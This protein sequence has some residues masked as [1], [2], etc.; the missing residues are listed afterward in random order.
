[1]QLNSESLNTSA[2]PNWFAYFAQTYGDAASVVGL[3]LSIGGLAATIVVALRA[4]SA[5]IQAR[6]AALA[7]QGKILQF[8]AIAEVVAAVSMLEQAKNLHRLGA[9]SSV[10]YYYSAARQSLARVRAAP[11]SEAQQAAITGIITTLRNFEHRVEKGPSEGLTEKLADLNRVIARE[12]DKLTALQQE[13]R[14]AGIE[15]YLPG[16]ERGANG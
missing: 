14:Q 2:L 10:I 15:S 16:A 5:A 8:D 7:A 6:D 1:M 11:L 3:V 12:I 9:W 4:R 13:M